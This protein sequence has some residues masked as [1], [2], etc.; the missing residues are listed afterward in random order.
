MMIE[1]I[2]KQKYSNG[3]TMFSHIKL[4]Q[5]QLHPGVTDRNLFFV[6]ICA[7]AAFY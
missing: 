1:P 7:E 3:R 5:S 2:L 6:K 4:G